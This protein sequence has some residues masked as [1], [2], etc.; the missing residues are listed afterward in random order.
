MAKL[1]FLQF[2]FCASSVSPYEFGFW[3]K[4]PCYTC[5]HTHRHTYRQIDI[6][7]RARKHTHRQPHTHT[8]T[9][10]HTHTH[11]HAHAH[12]HTHTH[13]HTHMCVWVSGEEVIQNRGVIRTHL[14]GE[15]WHSYG[16]TVKLGEGFQSPSSPFCHLHN[17]CL[18]VLE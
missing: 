8:C 18:N 4:Q 14:Y 2:S 10:A 16:R 9:C 11:A 13:T 5:M 15:K 12:T 17:L 1:F 6:H 7:T 3:M